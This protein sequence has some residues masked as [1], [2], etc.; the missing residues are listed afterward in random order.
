MR[1]PS[2][3]VLVFLK[4][5]RR[6][7]LGLEA[8]AG[9][10]WALCAVLL[11]VLVIFLGFII[12]GG[13]SWVRGAVLWALPAGLLLVLYLYGL[14]PFFRFR[15]GTPLAREVERRLPGEPMRLELV[16][17]VQLD[18]ALPGLI[19]RPVVSP[20]LVEAHLE[21][22]AGRLEGIRPKKVASL[23]RVLRPVGLLSLL[24]AAVLVLWIIFPADL[25]Q[26]V[27]SMLHSPDAPLSG[28]ATSE[29]S[30][31]GDIRLVY[32]YPDYTGRKKREVEG[33]D[34][35]ILALP[36]TRVAIAS[37]TDRDIKRASLQ[38]GERALE[39]RV[40]PGRRLEGEMVV[41]RAGSYRFEL[42]DQ[43]GRKWLEPRAHAINLEADRHPTVRLT[44]PQEDLVVREQDALDLLYDARD[45]FGLQ[46]IRLVY[47]V[48]SRPEGEQRRVLARFLKSKRRVRR[49]DFRWDLAVLQLEPGDT[50]QFYIE[51]LDSDTVMGPKAGRSA[52]R[53]LKVFSAREHHQTLNQRAQQLWEKLLALLGDA[54]DLDPGAR[55]EQQ[56]KDALESYKGM[57]EKTRSFSGDL[58]RLIG[59]MHKDRLTWRPLLAALVNTSSGVRQLSG[60]LEYYLDAGKHK[61]DPGFTER[62]LTGHRLRRVHRMERDVLYLEDLLD[63]MRLDD[64]D[65]IAKELDQA[66]RRLSE[67]MQQYAQAPNDE[68]RKKIEAEIARLKEKI[69]KLLAR[70]A[71]VLKS[72]R[73]EY[74]NPEALKKMLSR[75]D[76]MGTL[77]K[78]Q[79]LM[80]E[81]KIDEALAELARLQK[82]LESLQSAIDRSRAEYGLGKYAKLAQAM[83][84]MQGELNMIT[85]TQRKLMDSTEKIRRR[86]IDRLKQTGEAKLK[87]LFRQLRKRVQKVVAKIE[88]IDKAEMDTYMSRDIDGILRNAKMLDMLLGALDV[89]GS[90]DTA[91]KLAGLTERLQRSLMGFARYEGRFDP[92][93]RKK[94]Q[95]GHKRSREADREA[96]TV[97]AELKKIMPGAAKLLSKQDLAGL[98]KLARR[99]KTLKERLRQM[100]L[101]M[102]SI[103]DQA[104]VFGQGAM[105]RIQRGSSHMQRAAGDLSVKRP[106]GAYPHQQSALSEL[107]ALQKAMQQSCKPGGG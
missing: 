10:F 49:R 53:N 78:I 13:L 43:K 104:P 12:T 44:K 61:R 18:Q 50:V 42:Q 14:R 91:Q 95:A 54:L 82:Q 25:A 68:V 70:Q 26:A 33:T 5:C 65:K 79:K 32:E 1:S 52:T 87:A 4:S 37:R 11:A 46:E 38:L 31:V 102:Q 90:L 62:M 86:L 88:G 17:A 73:D 74:L 35:T 30:W 101:Q 27:G 103:N 36:G 39:L 93:R 29:D 16:S 21:A 23:K 99:Q 94:L 76:M 6:R 97:L 22:M 15:P 3:Q 81:G 41:M 100:G 77:D 92:S 72:I 96:Q 98:A 85:E 75:R 67:L 66:R 9:L 55:K 57:H 19:E 40:A 47:R 2:A 60:E 7:I 83:A 20:D 63:L 58:S 8:A 28:S 64:L 84:K 71:D 56:P 34:G 89:A 105:S 45:D 69:Q 59:D 106:R 48:S 80:M 107:Q 51:G 24:S